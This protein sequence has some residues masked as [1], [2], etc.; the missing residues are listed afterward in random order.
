MTY[1]FN[2]VKLIKLRQ[3]KFWT[4]E[5]LAAASGVSV[6]TVQRMETNNR[7]SIE[8]WKAIAAAFNVTPDA[9]LTASANIIEEIENHESEMRRAVLGA[10]LCCFAGFVGCSFGWWTLIQK[11]VGFHGAISDYPILTAYVT[12]A[13]AV[14]LIIPIM[15]WTRTLPR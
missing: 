8:S 13:T 11:P 2:S 6:R 1:T 7:A 9:L 10:I 12:F 4:Q 14:C 15:T 5:D 3:E